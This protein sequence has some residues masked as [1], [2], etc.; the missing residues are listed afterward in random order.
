MITMI[1]N[2][3]GVAYRTLDFLGYP[4]YRVGD[5]G[6]LW[7]WIKKKKY[8]K[9]LKCGTRILLGKHG[10]RKYKC[11]RLTNH[12]GNKQFYIHRLVLLA[13]VGVSKNNEIS[14]HNDDNGLNNNLSNLSWG[15]TKDN[16]EDAERNGKWNKSMMKKGISHHT[17]TLTEEQVKNI[18]LDLKTMRNCDI[19]RKYNV[20]PKVIGDIK[21]NR[22]WKHI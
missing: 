5:D 15:T 11:C 14:L 17:T 16:Q 21:I 3:N 7:R 9:L 10:G 18:K 6:S 19:A 22:T 8:W 12:L 1:Y 4:K 13:F 2:E 20:K